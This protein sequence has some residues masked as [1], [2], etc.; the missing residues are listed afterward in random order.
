L[1][2]E[3]ERNKQHF[4]ATVFWRDL[5]EIGV[6]VL[7]VPILLW[8]GLHWKLPWTF[9]LMIPAM[10]WIAG[11]MWVDRIRQKR[12][13]PRPG[14]PLRDCLDR[15]L[16]Q[17]EHQ[18]WLLRNVFWWYLLPPGVAAAVFFG[19]CLW[20]AWSGGWLAWVAMAGAI[21]VAALI[22]WAV[23]GLNRHAVRRDLEP[24]RSELR[25]LM[26]SLENAN[27]D[28]ATS[29]PVAGGG[30]ARGMKT[31]WRLVLWIV[32]IIAGL[33]FLWFVAEFFYDLGK[34]RA[35][36]P[37]THAASADAKYCP[38]AGDAAVTNRLVPI[39][40]KH[41]VPAIAAALVTSQ[42]IV[43]SGVVGTRKQGTEVAAT[44]ADKWH[45][46]SDTKAMTATLV[47]KL[48]EEGR[49][50]WDTTLAEVFRELAPRFHPEV[51]TI[52]LVQLLS[53]RSGLP[54]N[55]DLIKYGG[56]DGRKERLRILENELSR[57]PAHRPGTHFEY[58][59]LGYTIAGAIIEKITGKSWEQAMQEEVF[60][61]LGMTSVGFGGTG[62]PG[63]IDQPW[64]HH[65]DG[66]PVDGNGPAM[67]NPP[68][69][70]P[71]GRVHCTIQDW[72]KF[73]A[74][75]LRGDRGE[76]A[77]LKPA[78]YRFLHTPPL[79]GDYALGWIVAERDWAGGLALNHGGDN[80]MNC[81]NVWVAPRR[82]FA[83]LICINQTGETAFKAS[84][85]VAGA[86]I[87]LHAETVTAEE[88]K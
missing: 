85:E 62:T 28:G 18:I 11:F 74:D 78:T 44:L 87:Q 21:A 30:P 53:H 67:D 4:E 63:R 75:Q 13:Q 61:P 51:Q 76:P 64:G 5:R 23:Y 19:H 38:T 45:L 27:A 77:L 14:D 70:S 37:A 43:A 40:Q 41:R 34:T 50:K 80:T 88:R 49:L 72:A 12:R 29:G 2:R 39:R 1:L 10:V 58:S 31:G 20:L 15:S 54:A 86:L 3:L 16:A 73:I 36:A 82:D 7:M 57:K 47:A 25:A 69:L 32:W 60:G 35:T 17:V 81:A 79:G 46:G 56:A 33:A 66:T 84:D 52:T 42:G 9:Y 65:A 6:A 71:A 59:N 68:V 26:A 22:L 55:P 48:V 83:V 8:M 24:R